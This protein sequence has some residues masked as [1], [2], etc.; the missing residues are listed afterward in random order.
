MSLQAAW[1][2]VFARYFCLEMNLIY[3][4]TVDED[5]NAWHHLPSVE[6]VQRNYPNPCGKGTGMEDSALNG[7]SALDGLVAAYKIFPSET[8]LKTIDKVFSG[9][10]TLENGE[11]YVAR[12][13][14]PFDK[15]SYY[16]ESSRDQYTHFVYS[17]VRFFDAD[18]CTDAQK[19]QITEVLVRIAEKCD[20]DVKPE[21]DYHM[22]RA[23]GKRGTVGKMAQDV[24]AHEWMR[25]PM[26]YLAAYH[27]S[28]NVH[29]KDMYLKYRDEA[30]E[31]SYGEL[32]PFSRMY[33]YLQ[34]QCSLR[35]V[36]DYD[37][38]I[39]EK[40]L[41]LMQKTA[42]YA[43]KKAIDN[44]KEFCKPSHKEELNRRFMRWDKAGF[45]YVDVHN[46]EVY[47]N[48]AQ[49]EW[50]ENVAFY[51]VREIGEG[52]AVYTMCPGTEFSSELLEA[53]D[54]I[55]N[56]IDYQKHSS[57]YAPLL[58][59]CAYTLCLEQKEKP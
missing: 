13:I 7:G 44:S 42:E 46:G 38:E 52:T 12:S 51:P 56:A 16:V 39:R 10:L 33:C 24:A 9:L 53:V 4:Y 18:F 11:G 15:K 49:S 27:V 25:L 55:L 30:V 2:N 21:N 34:M 36:Y 59:G 57:V 41:P 32:P 31:K 5:G 22:L 17:L 20:R 35:V 58:L 29:W 45:R 14:S 26:F 47:K 54:N 48:P 23:D 37:P 19:A 1:E 50:K 6:E 40:I 8:L 28:G 43:K 3:D